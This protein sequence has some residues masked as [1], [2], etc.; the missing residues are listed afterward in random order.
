MQIASEAV[1]RKRRT[2][3]LCLS[4]PLL[5][6]LLGWGLCAASLSAHARVVDDVGRLL[7]Q[8]NAREA[9]RQ[10]DNHLKQNPGDVEMRFLRGVIATE[11]K[12]NAQAIKIFSALVREYPAMPEPYN[13][14]AVLYAA[15]GQER[16]A[17]EALEQ[18]IRTNP[19]YTTAHENLG[20]LYARMAS[21]AYTKALQLDGSRQTIPAKLALIT[22]LVPAPQGTTKTVVAQATPAAAPA[23]MPAPAVAPVPVAAVPPKPVEPK[24]EPKVEKKPAAAEIKP[25]P[26]VVETKPPVRTAAAPVAVAPAPAPVAPAAAPAPAVVAKPAAAP[27]PVAP[28]V[29]APKPAAESKPAA[30]EKP[31]APAKPAVDPAVASIESAVNDWAN[32]WEKQDMARYLDAYSEK[33]EPGNGASLAQWKESRRVRIVGK[34]NISI[35][36]QNIQVSVNGD[37]AT[38]KFRQNY[39]AG[40][41]VTTT[42]KTLSMR[43]E[44]GQWRIVR[45]STGG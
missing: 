18:A 29:A 28:P 36:L 41:L 35:T 21:E 6:V 8:G 24:P 30:E 4:R 11:Q 3:P 22:Q 5:A 38:A 2:T 13:N 39:N 45:E 23:A 7:D 42:R 37:Q 19:S 10:A 32:A 31:A 20:D 15:E 40:S 9:A 25:A 27:A 34:S 12:Q 17:A 26:V 16:K 1:S 43:N 44:R 14:L 33:F